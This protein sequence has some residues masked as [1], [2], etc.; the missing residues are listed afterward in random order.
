MAATIAASPAVP[1]TAESRSEDV[2]S[3]HEEAR[4]LGLSSEGAEDEHTARLL[5]AR[6][7]H[8]PFAR[9]PRRP[10]AAPWRAHDAPAAPGRHPGR[11][12]LNSGRL[13]RATMPVQRQPA[14]ELTA[15]GM[16]RTRPGRRRSDSG[17]CRS[18]A[19][20]PRGGDHGNA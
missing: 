16:A 14:R 17:T 9:R 15:A 5:Y 18:A 11:S 1:Q 19:G 2:Y 6:L 10:V 3:A 20:Y 7:T 13:G 4:K 8:R 12:C